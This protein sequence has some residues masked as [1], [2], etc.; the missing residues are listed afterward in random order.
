M[1]AIAPR[2]SYRIA[3][4]QEWLESSDNVELSPAAVWATDY[5]ED[6]E[7]TLQGK[8]VDAQDIDLMSPNV[9]REVLFVDPPRQVRILDESQVL[10]GE[11]SFATISLNQPFEESVL[12][13]QN[14]SQSISNS[15]V[16]DNCERSSASRVQL[17]DESYVLAGEASFATVMSGESMKAPRHSPITEFLVKTK[18]SV[19]QL[20]LATVAFVSL[21]ALGVIV[22][23]S[24]TRSAVVTLNSAPPPAVVETASQSVPTS[25]AQ[26]PEPVLISNSQGNA[27]ESTNPSQLATDKE[28][29]SVAETKLIERP[30]S[31]D[32][33]KTPSSDAKSGA[34]RQETLRE[35]KERVGETRKQPASVAKKALKEQTSNVVIKS[36]PGEAR[37]EPATRQSELPVTKENVETKTPAIT[38]GGERPRTVTRKPSP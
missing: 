7:T 11:A 37:P 2:S 10:P 12:K 33:L 29:T 15:S 14:S 31:D 16:N 20:V 9:E 32:S 8:R 3:D 18:L 30:S 27:S 1:S 38:G 28:T 5:E 17:L 21:L 34:V 23:L 25:T 22:L 24:M 19:R 4:E 13:P 35:P 26:S 36:E 6:D